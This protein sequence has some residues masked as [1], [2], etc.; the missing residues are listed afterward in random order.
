MSENVPIAY[1]RQE[2]IDLIEPIAGSSPAQKINTSSTAKAAAQATGSESDGEA[3]EVNYQRAFLAQLVVVASMGGFLFGY[4][5][6]I[7]AGA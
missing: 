4:D 6:G 5:T 2:D 3:K 1:R 7:V